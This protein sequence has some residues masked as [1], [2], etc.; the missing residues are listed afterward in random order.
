M[1]SIAKPAV[2]K[3]AI[4]QLG[5]LLAVTT[6]VVTFSGYLA[7]SILAGGLLHLV[8]HA[9]FAHVAYRYTGAKQVQSVLRGFYWGQVGKLVLTAALVV[10]VVKQPYS[11]NFLV[12]FIT[13]IVMVPIHLALVAKFLSREQ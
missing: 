8:P 12:V 13:F 11:V 3:V 7:G 9:W 1:T 6:A 10:V 5:L 2:H 4:I